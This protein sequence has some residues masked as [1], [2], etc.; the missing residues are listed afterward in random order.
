MDQLG[1]MMSPLSPNKTK[2]IPPSSSKLLLA[3]KGPSGGSTSALFKFCI[4]IL[5]FNVFILF[6]RR[7]R[8]SF[9]VVQNE[10]TVNSSSSEKKS[11]NNTIVSNILK[12]EEENK[13]NN[14]L[15]NKNTDK[16]V[17]RISD[18]FLDTLRVS[19]NKKKTT[20]EQQ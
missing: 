2:Q 5:V 16:N 10:M 13:N 11:G 1:V 20:D 17:R 9:Q 8:A 15:L 3:R 18:S 4:C 7:Q 6:F 14:K 12:L 19:K